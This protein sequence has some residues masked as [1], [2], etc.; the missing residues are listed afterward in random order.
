MWNKN[1]LRTKRT[2]PQSPA[3]VMVVVAS[4]IALMI[5]GVQLRGAEARSLRRNNEIES[6]NAV[7]GLRNA[8]QRVVYASPAD[9]AP[10]TLLLLLLQVANNNYNNVKDVQ[11]LRF[12]AVSDAV[13]C[14]QVLAKE[15]RVDVRIVTKEEEE[16]NVPDAT[17][18]GNVKYLCAVWPVDEG[19]PMMTSVEHM[20][21]LSANGIERRYLGTETGE[22][23]LGQTLVMHLGAKS[24]NSRR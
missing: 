6:A 12:H 7:L 5:T 2:T 15:S 11:G 1:L 18:D 21:W 17:V 14:D 3:A 22:E 8:L 16:G 10:L 13:L 19:G 9:E 4:V 20:E 23:E 24:S